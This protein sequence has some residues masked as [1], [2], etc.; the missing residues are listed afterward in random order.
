MNN[1]IN[2]SVGFQCTT[3]EILKKKNQRTSSFPFDWILSNPKGIFNL[4]TKLMTIDDIKNFVINEFLYCKSYLK[5]IKPEEFITV[6][7]SN[8]F[9]NEKYNF[10]FPHESVINDDIINKY[11][12]RFTRLK[13]IIENDEQNIH[14]YF[15]NRLNN[16]N[17]KIDNKNILC[18]I[19][20]D[21][22]NLYNF[23]YKYKKDKLLFTIITTNNIDITKIDKN[24]KTHILNTKSD[25]LTDTEIMNSLIDKKYTFITGKDGFGGQYQRIIQTMIYCKHH[26]L[27][28]VYRP[29][30]K[31]EHNYNNDTKYIDNIEKLMNIK[32]KVEN[33]TNNEAEELDYGSVVMKWFEKNIDIACNSEDLRLIKSYFW[34]NKERNVF[35]NDKINVSVHIRRKNQH[36][37][38]LGHNDSVGGRATSNDYFLNI[39][40]HIRKKDKNIRF[41]IYSQGKIENFE[42]YKNKDTKLHINEDISK[43][44][45]ELVAADILV[46]SAS[47]FS[48]VAALLSDG[49]VYYKKFWH[50]PRKNWIVC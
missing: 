36:D 49:E 9:Y 7:I 20:D 47:S 4:L 26:N 33:D 11:V 8:I 24:I 15:V 10:I 34:Q 44:F 46:T 45:I 37:V 22:N 5:F 2:I 39:I 23:F 18:N 31:M 48:Y 43:T 14:I 35:N 32:N 29:I 38:L 40:E 6:N 27:N 28:F 30:K 42:I 3:A 1:Y 12:R 13:D 17:F 41:H 21:L 50:N 16:M 19:E 25:S